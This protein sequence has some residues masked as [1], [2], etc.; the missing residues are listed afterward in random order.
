MLQ[1]TVRNSRKMISAMVLIID[2]NSKIVEHTKEQPLIFDLF[3]GFD[4][5]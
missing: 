4:Q 2:G 5:I 1:T 3:K